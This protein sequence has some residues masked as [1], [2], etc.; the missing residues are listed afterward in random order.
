M[1][2]AM[3][4]A[5]VD[6][7]VP[8]VVDLDGTLVRTDLLLELV[9][10]LAKRSPLRLLLVP[11]WLAGGKARLKRRL[12]AEARPD[13]TVLPY[14][15]DLLDRLAAEKRR[16]RPLV[17]ATAADAGVAEDVA[18]HLGLFDRVLASDGEVNLAGERKRDR[19]VA[20]FGLQGFDFVGSG[21]SDEA[22][23]RA[24]RRAV[25]IETAPG[26]ASRVAKQTEVVE[27]LP[28]DRPSA[29]LYLEALRP[30]QW[31]KNALVFLPLLAAHRIYE[32]DLLSQ[33]LLVLLAFSLC[34]SSAYLLNDLL[35]LPSDRHH[36]RKRDRPLA[37]GR[38]PL[39]HGLALAPLLLIT[40]LALGALSGQLL[41][42]LL[43]LYYVLTM[44]YSLRLKDVLI[45]DVL[46]L[47]GLYTLR[48]MAGSAAF[49]I[50]PS[51]WL[52]AFCVF[53]FF[54]LAMIKRY[55]ELVAMRAVEGVK[56]HARAYLLEDKELLAAL[57]GASG[58]LSV[59]VLALYITSDAMHDLS[60]RYQLIWLVCV[61]LLYWISYMWLMAHRGRMLDDPLVFAL[62][63]RVSQI[64]IALMAATLLIAA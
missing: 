55:A 6:R 38:L 43:A 4:P 48:V 29:A 54:S 16:G 31:L 26:L 13:A 59:L 56:A 57:G 1:P 32:P 44:S 63:D 20:E 36:P 3:V 58:Y 34:A 15:P 52:L 42:G 19:L 21:R 10:T 5:P 12:A 2:D 51:A 25:V 40:G 30:H 7:S 37:S 11:L 50:P 47:A 28:G 33:G 61:L 46:A 8:L 9:F 22:P 23:W 62:R 27:I 60:V 39:A 18:R 64:V 41:V 49:A 35:D 17:L 45:L 24:A 14:R 53:L